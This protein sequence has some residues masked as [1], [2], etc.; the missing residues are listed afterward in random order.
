MEM[1]F[2]SGRGAGRGRARGRGGARAARAARRG[3][4][5]RDAGRAPRAAAGACRGF[6]EKPREES[7]PEA[8]GG[9]ALKTSVLVSDGSTSARAPAARTSARR[10]CLNFLH[11]E[12]AAFAA[13]G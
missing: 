7:I 9:R 13:L 11:D 1:R 4:R 10:R 12:M 5:R 3:A 8:E 6:S 2:Y